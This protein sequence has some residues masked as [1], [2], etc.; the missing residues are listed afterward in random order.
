MHRDDVDAVRR[1]RS[2]DEEAYRLL[3]QRHS[4][5]LY[6]LA[7]RM[8]GQRADAEDVH[9][10]TF[11]R[12]FR[13][14]DRFEA[15]SNF[16]TW[17]YRIGYNCAID[18]LRGRPR[19]ESVE[20]PEALAER[21]EG[22][23]APTVDDLVYATEIGDRVQAA[24]NGLTA[25]ERAAFLLRHYDGCSIGEICGALEL[26]ASAAKHA[27]FRAVRK[28]RQAL[29]PLRPVLGAR[30]GAGRDEDLDETPRTVEHIARRGAMRSV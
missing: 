9:Q 25:Q 24:L 11:V 3:V 20:G 15:R 27:V 8:T 2:G 6:R 12:A 4:R 21:A 29:E 13:Q 1:A 22:A 23:G 18:H 17:L 19:H 28:M 26:N 16:A 30:R 5:A 7:F 14:L 10:D